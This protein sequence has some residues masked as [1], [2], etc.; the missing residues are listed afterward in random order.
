MRSS[1]VFQLQGWY[2]YTVAMFLTC[3]PIVTDSRSFTI[4]VQGNHSNIIWRIWEQL[5]QQGSGGGPWYHNLHRVIE[6][7]IS[8]G[9][10]D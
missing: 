4:T 2:L 6:H 3:L 7:V 1:I 8:F 10:L 5:L 9:K